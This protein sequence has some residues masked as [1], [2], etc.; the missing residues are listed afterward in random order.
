LFKGSASKAK[1]KKAIDYVTRDDKAVIVSSLSMDD[2]QGY[3]KQFKETC[4]IYGKG[5]GH[6]ERKY[7]HFKLSCDPADNPTPE[8][9]H[10]LAEKLAQQLFS[11]HECVIATHN[12]TGVVHSHI[13]VNA[14]SFETGKKLHL[15][16]ANKGEKSYAHCKDLADKLG[17]EMGLTPLDWRNKAKE[18]HDRTKNG[19]A[20]KPKTLSNAERNISK[21]DI[22][23]VESWKDAL[24]Q[25]IDEAK[26]HCTDRAGFQQYLL[27][28]FGVRMTRNTAKTV[29][30]VRPA[31]GEN[32]AVRGAKLG[33]GYTAVGIDEALKENQERSLLN[34]GLFV[35]AE[36]AATGRDLTSTKPDISTVVSQPASQG[37][38]RKR[39]IT[40]SVGDISAELRNIDE[41]VSRIANGVSATNEGRNSDI[42]TKLHGNGQ[43]ND[44]ATG[45]STGDDSR[46]RP[47]PPRTVEKPP[48][49]EPS[50]QRKPKKRTY[51]H[52]R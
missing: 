29:T 52:E 19:I 20:D 8:Q 22:Q 36:R 9:S 39:I 10:K 24:R 12:D 28:S 17:A 46:E 40:R 30:F 23:G 21:R 44:K 27:E 5:S 1:P 34:A 18:R 14:V 47:E 42:S 35:E 2:S 50:V 37:R 31:V 32:Y 11:D 41:A 25:A 16:K 38:D 7:Y 4:D 45:G 15:S 26:A 6:N 33:K 51:S 13:I 48:K 3:A 43:L 49:H